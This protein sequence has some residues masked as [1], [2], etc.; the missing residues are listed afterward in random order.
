M[1]F[2]ACLVMCVICS[3]LMFAVC[4][5]FVRCALSVVCCVVFGVLCLVFCAC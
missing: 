5:C 1:L 4:L 2:D 3:R